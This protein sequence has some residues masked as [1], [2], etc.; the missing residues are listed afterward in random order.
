M[1]KQQYHHEMKVISN[2][3]KPLG[4]LVVVRGVAGGGYLVVVRVV[5][6]VVVGRVVVGRG[7]LYETS[8][9]HC[10]K[11]YLSCFFTCVSDDAFQVVVMLVVVIHKEMSR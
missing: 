5:G 11:E 4:Y 1:S 6:R 9:Q 3:K 8:Y 7:V 10:I 2:K